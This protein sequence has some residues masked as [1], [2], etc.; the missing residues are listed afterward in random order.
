MLWA[1]HQQLDPL[2]HTVL[3]SPLWSTLFS[4][5]PVLVLFWLL[6]PRRY[7][8]S[9]PWFSVSVSPSSAHGDEPRPSAIR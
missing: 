4:A 1:Y 7:S 5:L 6:V 9:D 2:H 3:W 8:D